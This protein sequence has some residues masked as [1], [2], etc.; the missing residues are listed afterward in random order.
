[1]KEFDIDN[2][3][4]LDIKEMQPLVARLM[5]EKLREMSYDPNEVLILSDINK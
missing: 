3:G 2:N 5:N 1:M 4:V